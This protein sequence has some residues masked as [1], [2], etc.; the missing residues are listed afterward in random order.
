MRAALAA[1]VLLAAMPATAQDTRIGQRWNAG[2]WELQS[3]FLGDRFVHCV[4]VG[5]YLSGISVGYVIDRAMVLS[6]RVAADDWN[7]APGGRFAVRLTIDGGPDLPVVGVAL[8]PTVAELA[9]P[10]TEAMFQALRTGT[11]MRLVPTNG[12]LMNFRLDGTARMLTELR[13]CA[14]R[15]G[16]RSTLP[17]S[18]DPFGTRAPGGRKGEGV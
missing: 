12:T 4:A 7:L 2:E 10:S 16:A 14:E 3:R 11:L 5:N 18:P 9:I 15:N 6:M 13:G 17:K 1:L 8:T